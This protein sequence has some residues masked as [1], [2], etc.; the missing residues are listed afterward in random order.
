[1]LQM[2]I[3]HL[4]IKEKVRAI[5][6]DQVCHHARRLDIHLCAPLFIMNISPATMMVIPVLMMMWTIAWMSRYH[7]IVDVLVKK[8]ST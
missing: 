6:D 3:P 4:E 5:S 7:V 1:M 2:N 8:G